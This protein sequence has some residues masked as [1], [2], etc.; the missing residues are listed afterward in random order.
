MM[1]NGVNDMN[2]NLSVNVAGVDTQDISSAR[3]KAM[4][5]SG[6][7]ECET[8]GLEYDTFLQTNNEFF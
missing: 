8:C 3:L 7:V 2:R 1:I 4:K 5:R 6:Q